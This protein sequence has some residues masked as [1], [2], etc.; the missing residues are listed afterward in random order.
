MTTPA[1]H[2]AIGPLPPAAARE[3]SPERPVGVRRLAWLSHGAGQAWRIRLSAAAAIV[4]TGVG[5]S[6]LLVAALPAA[7]L[8]IWGAALVA[9]C[10]AMDAS[11]A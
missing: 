6:A 3:A 5:F 10:L 4:L 9:S 11:R 2:E 1:H 8:V 7:L